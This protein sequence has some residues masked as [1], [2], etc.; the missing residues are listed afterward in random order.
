M[1][2]AQPPVVVADGEQAVVGRGLHA[3]LGLFEVGL[4][5]VVVDHERRD[6]EV[7]DREVDQSILT[8][9]CTW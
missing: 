1:S 6:V 7:V 3:V 8:T 2:S 9:L 5:Q 4:G